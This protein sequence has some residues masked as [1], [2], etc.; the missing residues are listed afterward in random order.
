MTYTIEELE[1]LDSE[2]QTGV[3]VSVRWKVT[4]SD[5]TNS[6]YCVK[7]SVFTPSPSSSFTPYVDLTETQVLGWVQDSLG[8]AGVAFYEN[9]I[10]GQLA[11]HAERF[12]EET[13]VD[14]MCDANYIPEQ[15]ADL[16]WA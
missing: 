3:V 9:L 6:G 12:P 5:E 10:V 1:C 15:Q 13:G 7:K 14:I 16:P 8:V 11:T 4:G 2:G